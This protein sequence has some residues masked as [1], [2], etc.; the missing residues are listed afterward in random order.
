MK[1]IKLSNLPYA[2]KLSYIAKLEIFLKDLIFEYPLHDIWYRKMINSMYLYQ[3]REI[4]LAVEKDIIIGTAILKNTASE[5]KICTLRVDKN[6]QKRGIG[7]A[8]IIQ[9]F[10]ILQTE[11]PIITVSSNKY[12]EFSKIFDYFGFD[13]EAVYEEKYRYSVDEF[14][15]N[16]ILLPESLIIPNSNLNLK[17]PLQFV[18]F[19]SSLVN[20][21]TA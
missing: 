11:R 14:V 20:I 15:Y 21:V 18:D 7:R 13:L 1:I 5:K 2:E 12:Q 4:L 10:E 3:E 17:C 19:R 6:Y 8:L 9:S 16:G